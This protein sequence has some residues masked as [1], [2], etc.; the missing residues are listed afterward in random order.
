MPKTHQLT[1]KLAKGETATVKAHRVRP[2]LYAHRELPGRYRRARGW[3]FSHH[4]G[5][6]VGV[7]ARTLRELRQKADFADSEVGP[8]DWASFGADEAP[9]AHAED[10]AQAAR[11][12]LPAGHVVLHDSGL[13]RIWHMP[14]DATLRRSSYGDPKR[15]SLHD[16]GL[17]RV[18]DVNRLSLA[19]VCA[20]RLSVHVCAF[21]LGSERGVYA[22]CL[23]TVLTDPEW[24][25]AILENDSADELARR[26][27]E[28]LVRAAAGFNA[29][30]DTY[31][32]AAVAHKG[33]K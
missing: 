19:E 31:I 29:P 6:S 5:L 24:Q 15:G 17:G 3:Q 13:T 27:S 23:D 10:W 22:Q 18:D 32:S 30:H 1:L 28:L 16:I 4:T 14:G 26:R 20:V 9:P 11:D 12:G 33:G 2:G 21:P 25:A 7:R 8:V